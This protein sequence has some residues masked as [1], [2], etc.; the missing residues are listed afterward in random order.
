MITLEEYAPRYEDWVELERGADGVLEATLH[1]E[2]GPWVM[3]SRARDNFGEFMSFLANDRENRVIIFTG[4]GEEFCTGLR[5]EDLVDDLGH[6]GPDVT[7]RWRFGGTRG[8]IK[9]LEIEAPVI[10]ALN[11]PLSVHPELWMGADIFLAAEHATIQDA[12]HLAN[13]L[14]VGG[15]AQVVFETLLGTPRAKY[16]HLT[17]QVL[18]AEE[19][20]S[21]GVV[22]EVLPPGELLPRAREHARRLAALDTLTLRYS[23]IAINQRLRRQLMLEQ[24]YGQG[25]VMLGAHSL[26][27]GEAPSPSPE[28]TG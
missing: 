22:H 18:G 5:Q 21:L 4:T 14:P 6:F 16:F 2:G 1:T 9:A 7:D 24:G 28:R 3:T 26:F 25:L 20:R 12:I 10:M 17:S 8:L 13:G 19:A 23:R 15:E 11:G 27:D